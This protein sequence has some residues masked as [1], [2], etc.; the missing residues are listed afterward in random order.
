V[1]KNTAQLVSTH[2]GVSC[3]KDRRPASI[4]TT[5]RN[6]LFAWKKKIG[7][8]QR[9][10]AAPIVKKVGTPRRRRPKLQATQSPFLNVNAALPHKSD[11]GGAPIFT[12]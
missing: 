2:R 7:R 11:G 6:Q 4:H 9:G 3:G 10:A 1:K 12:P 5:S 8:R